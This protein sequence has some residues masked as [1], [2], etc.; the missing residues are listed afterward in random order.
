MNR[1][2]ALFTCRAVLL[3]SLLSSF[4]T[5]QTKQVV[6]GPI[7]TQI[8]TAKKVFIANAGGDDPE[9][10]NPFSAE[11]SIALTTSSMTR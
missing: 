3:L 1:K 7:P 2:V 6:P 5:A 10:T 11:E 8:I 9:S 4:M